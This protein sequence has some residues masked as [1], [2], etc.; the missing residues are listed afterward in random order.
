MI[1][2]H[3]SGSSCS[4]SSIEPFTSANSTVTCLRSPSR[5]DV[6]AE[7]LVGEVFGRVGRARSRGG[8]RFGRLC[9]ADAAARRRTSRRAPF[10][11]PHAAQ[12]RP[13]ASAAFAAELR[14]SERLSWSQDGQ[15]I[16]DRLAC[17][18]Y[19]DGLRCQNEQSP[20]WKGTLWPEIGRKWTR[21]ESRRARMG[22]VGSWRH[23]YQPPTLIHSSSMGSLS[24]PQKD[25]PSTTKNGDPKMPR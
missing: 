21:H 8:C 7:D 19:H 24:Q 2:C 12:P 1:A 13:S 11:A 22:H 5:A 23:P 10:G 25:S 14:R 18:D 3:S 9:S 4:A 16:G 15:R 17:G 20:R 6:R